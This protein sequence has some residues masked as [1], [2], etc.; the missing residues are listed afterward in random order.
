MLPVLVRA[1][2]VRSKGKSNGFGRR[3]KADS[4]DRN[5]EFV[6]VRAADVLVYV[7]YGAAQLGVVG[8]DMLLENEATDIFHGEVLGI[9]KCKLIVGALEGMDYAKAVK[10]G[11]QLTVATKYP[12]LARAYMA[13]Q[14]VQAEIV[15][16]YGSM[17]LAP[18]VNLSDVIVDLV[19]TGETM[20]AN[21]LREVATI[22]PISTQLI[23]NQAASWRR[24]KDITQLTKRLLKA[25]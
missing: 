4:L 11:K 17:E 16:L 23:Y 25:L 18:A 7:S 13:Q 15:K 8:R 2:L 6:L 5:I 19:D 22:M 24:G 10:N 14:G 1:G 21:G 20:R 3:I 9:A 12:R